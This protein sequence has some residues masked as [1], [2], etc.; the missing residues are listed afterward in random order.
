MAGRVEIAG[1]WE[2]GWSAPITEYDQWWAVMRSFDISE[3]NMTPVSGIAKRGVNEY[4][5]MEALIE[6]K[7]YLTP[8]F[9]HEDAEC[10]LTDFIHPL[11]ALYIFGKANYSPFKDQADG[12]M[13]V[14]IDCPKMGMLW[15]HQAL[16]IVMYERGN[17]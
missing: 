10:G 8:V 7:P 16:S 17:L 11:D 1:V 12:K 2:L 13:S 6:A 15:P 3:M 4:P 9:V 14:R 5:T